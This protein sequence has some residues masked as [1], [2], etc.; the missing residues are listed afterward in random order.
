MI[1]VSACERRVVCASVYNDFNA[2]NQTLTTT[3]LTTLALATCAA[4]PRGVILVLVVLEHALHAGLLLGCS[5]WG[6]NYKPHNAHL[7]WCSTLD[8]V[9]KRRN[10]KAVRQRGKAWGTLVTKAQVGPRNCGARIG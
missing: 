8:P 2:F 9:A 3:A 7:A 10:R 5:L 1:V 6:H 4:R